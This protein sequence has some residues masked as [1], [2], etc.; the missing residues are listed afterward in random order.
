MSKYQC[1]TCK[2]TYSDV[3]PDGT[4]YF[5]V[6]P[7]ETVQ[8]AVIS[9]AGVITTP[10]KRTPTDNVRDERPFGT[11][12]MLEGKQFWADPDPTHDKPFLLTPY[13]PRVK[14]EGAG[15]TL[16]EA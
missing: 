8:H 7:P 3:Q 4:A 14:S 12:V 5:H 15:R 6:C 16:I 10:E 1:N 13:A 2:G 11:V 9:V